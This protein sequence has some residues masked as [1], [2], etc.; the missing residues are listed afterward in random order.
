M[1]KELKAAFVKLLNAHYIER[2]PTP[3]PSLHPKGVLEP[4]KKAARGAV[5]VS[6]GQTL[7]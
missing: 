3:E 2:C 7:L 4:P 1:A 5:G 6:V